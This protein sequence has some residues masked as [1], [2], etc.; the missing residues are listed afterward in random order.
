MKENQTFVTE[1]ILT[2]FSISP[3]LHIFLFVLFLLVYIITVM[4]NLLITVVIGS[5]RTLHIPMYLFLFVLSLSES[6]YSLVIIP[7]MLLDLLAKS[8]TISF[9]G[10]A[11]Q[12][13]FFLGLG[14]T[15][16]FILTIMGFDR[17]LAICKP[18]HY[19]VLMNTQVILWLVAFSWVAGFLISVAEIILIFRLP[20]C[21]SNV[22]NHFFCH[23]RTVVRLA[24]T[25]E[26][27]TEVVVSAI[28]I[29]GL[30]GSFLFIILTYV[31][32]LSTIFR[33]PST[34][35]WQKAFSTCASHLIVV[36]MHYGFAAIVYLRPNSP[37][38]LD[39][40]TLISIPYTIITPLLSPVI[41]TLRN[42]EIKFAVRKVISKNTHSPKL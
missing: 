4:G 5:D 1:F 36:I 42:K 10:C 2:G 3:N 38:T 29:F 25:D 34:D 7:K 39:N 40:D 12:M 20:F 18:L 23:M 26:S 32:I 11:A 16:C 28:S 17:Y 24:C 15:N 9:A 27:T 33:I 41:F 13:F 31:F 21:D 8:K 14:G 22:I 30:S 35:G 19:P 37:G 6:C